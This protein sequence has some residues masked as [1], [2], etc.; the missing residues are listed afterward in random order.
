MAQNI[1]FPTASVNILCVHVRSGLPRTVALLEEMGAVDFQRH[2]VVS[3]GWF[4]SIQFR[5]DAACSGHCRLVAA[6]KP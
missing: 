6:W 4:N 5:L 1:P 2:N 3:S